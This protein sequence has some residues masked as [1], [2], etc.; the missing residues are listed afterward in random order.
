MFSASNRR[1]TRAS[2]QVVAFPSRGAVSND[3]SRSGTISRERLSQRIRRARY[4]DS[5]PIGRIRNVQVTVR[6]KKPA[7]HTA[8]RRQPSIDPADVTRT[9][10]LIG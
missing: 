1:R 8:Y 5:I 9:P 7:A 10:S 3:R 6:Q 2:V 4:R